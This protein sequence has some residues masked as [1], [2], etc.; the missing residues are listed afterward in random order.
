MATERL[1]RWRRKSP[2][3]VNLQTAKKV[4]LNP[5]TY[6]LAVLYMGFLLSGY[7]SNCE[8]FLGERSKFIR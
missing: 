1:T 2:K 6:H 7:G 4:A 8:C 5:M 3:K